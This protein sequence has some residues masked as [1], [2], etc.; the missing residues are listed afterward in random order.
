M[1]YWLPVL[2]QEA[3]IQSVSIRRPGAD[4]GKRLLAGRFGGSAETS[5]LLGWS[6]AY[7]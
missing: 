4:R 5:E 7:N 6:R 2:A 1:K 3:L